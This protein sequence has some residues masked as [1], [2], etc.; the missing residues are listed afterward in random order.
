MDGC[1]IAGYY[2]VIN[3]GKRM[4]VASYFEF[5]VKNSFDR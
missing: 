4:V 2:L 1:V 3:K 5:E